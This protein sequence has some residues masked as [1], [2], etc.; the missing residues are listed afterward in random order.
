MIIRL[1]QNCVSDVYVYE[2]GLDGTV[3]IEHDPFN[4]HWFLIT[5]K[6][7]DVVK[8]NRDYVIEFTER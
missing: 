6:G 2:I 8:V 3:S 4:S 7:G 5:K 1:V